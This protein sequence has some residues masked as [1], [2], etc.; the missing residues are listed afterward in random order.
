MELHT[1]SHP[2]IPNILFL[3][4][5]SEDA[6][7][8]FSPSRPLAAPV[9]RPDSLPRLWRYINLLLNYSTLE[10]ARMINSLLD[11]SVG[12]NCL[13]YTGAMSSLSWFQ[14]QAYNNTIRYD[15][16]RYDRREFNVD[17]KGSIDRL[18]F[19]QFQQRFAVLVLWNSFRQK[20]TELW[21]NLGRYKRFFQKIA[22]RTLHCKELQ[23][24]TYLITAFSGA[25]FFVT[26][27][28]LYD[29]AYNTSSYFAYV[30]LLS[31]RHCHCVA[32]I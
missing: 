13:W 26:K 29:Q 8:Y 19:T 18:Y 5:S 27:Y 2:P 16:I 4:T 25:V 15:T 10:A 31:G 14:R 3:Q 22:N 7:L 11:V 20:I 21:R 12:G 28:T 9:M 30:G 17:L 32:L 24:I 1:S 6:L 23:N